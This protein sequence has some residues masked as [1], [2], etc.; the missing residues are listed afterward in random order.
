MP[1][2]PPGGQTQAHGR[3]TAPLFVALALANL[4][5]WVWALAAF[6]DRRGLMMAAF[7]AYVF[8]LR[9][10]VDADHIAA[11]DNVT[12]KL[13]QAGQRPLGVGLSFSLG[14]STVVALACLV[15]ALTSRSLVDRFGWLSA[16]GG[17]VGT[18]VSAGFLFVIALANLGVLIQVARML[19][20]VRCGRPLV[21][22]ELDAVL[23]QRGFFGRMLKKVVALV[24]GSWGMYPL[25]F[26]FGLGFDTATEVGV[27]GLSAAHGSADLPAASVMIFPALF[28]AGMSLV[29]SAD[30]VLMLKA[31]SWALVRPARK[32]WYNLVVTLV[33]VVA[34]VVIGAVEV[35]GLMTER[36]SLKGG[37][38]DWIAALGEHSGLVGLTIVMTCLTAWLVAMAA[39]RLRGSPSRQG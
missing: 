39:Y 2:A 12:R 28:A 13:V 23:G 37:G 38:W 3:R 1:A 16:V 22:A 24:S 27:L 26:L 8:G 6:H 21:E 11:I 32:L 4:A 35:A 31:Y 29:D 9:H 20:G 15:I 33:S 18:M 36:L 25:G 30:G 17:T 19:Q 7:L 14:H 34:A 5:A 10:A